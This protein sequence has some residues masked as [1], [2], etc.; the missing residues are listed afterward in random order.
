MLGLGDSSYSNFN[1]AAK[2]LNKRLINLGAKPVLQIGLADDQHDLG[3]DAVV[4]PWIKSLWNALLDIY[5][6]PNGISI[7]DEY[8]V[9]EPR[10]VIC[11]NTVTVS[12]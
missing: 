6:L 11:L 10:L 1:F 2:K 5:P 7:L 9:C 8:I 4:D 12:C 3:A